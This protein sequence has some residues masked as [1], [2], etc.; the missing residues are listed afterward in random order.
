LTH[1][2]DSPS[3]E[4]E[5]RAGQPFS[6]RFGDVYFSR[7]SGIAETRHVF[8]AGNA[9]HERWASLAAGA[10]FVVAETGF[11]TGLNFLCAW[12][13]WE[14][15]APRDARLH[16][17]SIEAYPLARDEIVRALAL[18]PP[19]APYRDALAARW[20]AFAPGWHR[21][22][23]A[24]GR[25]ILTLLVGDIAAVLPRLDAVVDAWF[26][27]G[28]APARNPGM[29]SP[30]ALTQVA[31]L[32]RPGTTFATYTAASEVRRNLE[33]VGFVVRK[34][35]GFG[36]KRE[37]LA[38]TLDTRAAPPWRA[39][40][41]ARPSPHAG[42]R[43]AIVVGGGP[44]GATTAASL[45]ARGWRV[46]VLERR[47]DTGPAAAPKHQG[48]LYA[49]PSPHPTALNEFAL[50]GL[51]YTAR[52]LR[53]G[54]VPDA[55]DFALCGVLQLACDEHEVKRQAGVAALTLPRALL[56]PVDRAEA[57]A[58]AGIQ[59]PQGG[60]FFPAAGWVHPPALCAALLDHPG[61]RVRSAHE[62]LEIA[63]AGAQ[64]TVRNG[65]SIV[66][67]APVVVIA[68]GVDSAGFPQTRHLP[69]RTIRGQ[70]TLVPET[71]AS[72]ALR[73]VLCGEG[74]V[75][76]ARGGVHS[77]GA[78]HKFH[79]RE[80]DVRA[81]EHAE[82]LERLGRLAPALH[83]ALGADRLDP[84]TLAG[85][86]GLR[87]SS[88]DYLPLIG[89]VVDA[90]A[91]MQAYA[92]LSHDRTLELRDPAPWLDGLYANTAHGSRG[93]IT[94][95][96]SGELIAA[97]LDGEPSP[98]PASVAEALHPSRFLLRGLIRRR[99]PDVNPA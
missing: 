73:T 84:V 59:V 31:H 5:W 66:A 25:V 99:T 43:R 80:T 93:L 88:P 69:L 7:D 40:W 28:F 47:G 49:H 56:R 53:A 39:P 72:A 29:W 19:L 42:E 18:W 22:A 6:R 3:G 41:F 63:R 98:L 78:T 23:F 21:L 74:Y 12:A 67:A 17:V 75:A 45:A 82:N 1:P 24:S 94:A 65:R 58:I 26:L 64:W 91:F 37:M 77:L 62:A 68:G 70:I 96:L 34:E 60:L 86:A 44:A 54:R 46:E 32:S 8:L 33:A 13:L 57:A 30:A 81:S 83:A 4:L 27:D 87:C 16:Y 61:I 95:P 89:P 92:R 14:E 97:Y 36:Q 48:V 76:P 85:L 11:G 51:Q 71:A 55:R 50:A 52:T 35:T 9:L 20:E 90:V 2:T 10:P 38:G 15:V 79:D